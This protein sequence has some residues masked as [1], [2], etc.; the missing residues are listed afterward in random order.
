M[1]TE[2]GAAINGD[3]NVVVEKLEILAQRLGRIMGNFKSCKKKMKGW[4]N[5][6]RKHISN[7]QTKWIK[8]FMKKSIGF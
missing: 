7:W 1:V 6:W 5:N 4:P 8:H 3:L 2:S